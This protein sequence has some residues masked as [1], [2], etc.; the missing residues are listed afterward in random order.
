MKETEQIRISIAVFQ[1]FSVS[2]RP[3][4]ELLPEEWETTKCSRNP[5]DNLIRN[6]SQRLSRN[7]CPIIFDE[8]QFCPNPPTPMSTSIG[9]FIRRGKQQRRGTCN[10]KPQRPKVGGLT[11]VAEGTGNLNYH[12]GVIL[13]YPGPV[14]RRQMSHTGSLIIFPPQS[15]SVWPWHQ[16]DSAHS[17]SWHHFG[18]ARIPPS[19]KGKEA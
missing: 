19:E 9:V 4:T 13:L 12:H 16:M 7:S 14:V 18:S 11:R 5:M 10:R 17:A 1:V 6:L 15:S 3:A 2:Q 8:L